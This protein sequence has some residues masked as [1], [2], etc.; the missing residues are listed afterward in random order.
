MKKKVFIVHGWGG[1]PEEDWLPW[2]KTQL[3]EKGFTVF[4]PQMPDTMRPQI[5]TWVPHLKKLVGKP[6]KNTFFVGHSMGCQTILRYLQSLPENSEVGGAILVAGFVHLTDQILET[7][8]DKE[9]AKPW[10]TTPLLWD[11]ILEHTR[12]IITIFSDDDPFVPLRDSTIFMKKL[13]AEVIIEKGKGH[14]SMN[15]GIYDLPVVLNA[16][17][18]MASR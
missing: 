4:V 6:N 14:I 11:K 17:L 3:E 5:E 16:L 18:R 8:D 15:E 1:T 9:I 2:L 7:E 13:G 10:L 12:H